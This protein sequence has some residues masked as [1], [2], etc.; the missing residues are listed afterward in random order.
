MKAAVFHCNKLSRVKMMREYQT[1]SV[2]NVIPLNTE[3]KNQVIS[4]QELPFVFS[5]F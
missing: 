2:Q 5:L 3:L 1:L 4:E